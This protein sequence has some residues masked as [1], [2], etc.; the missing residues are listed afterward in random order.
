M[1]SGCWLGETG[2][3]WLRGFPPAGATQPGFWAGLGAVSDNE[4]PGDSKE[5]QTGEGN[6]CPAREE[7]WEKQE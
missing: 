2:T 5:G 4:G 7:T 6:C 1:A 3:E